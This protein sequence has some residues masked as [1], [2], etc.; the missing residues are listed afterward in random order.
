MYILKIPL[1]TYLP[2]Q[3]DNGAK[4]WQMIVNLALQETPAQFPGFASFEAKF[5]PFPWGEGIL[6][7]KFFC[8]SMFI[9]TGRVGSRVKVGCGSHI[10]LHQVIQSKI[11]THLSHISSLTS[12]LEG[13]ARVA[14]LEE[15]KMKTGPYLSLGCPLG[16]PQLI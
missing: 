14:R 5:K 1:H 15:V 9:Q 2:L 13:P 10:F 8:L 3:K 12:K 7:R 6:Q 4:P 11:W 16:E